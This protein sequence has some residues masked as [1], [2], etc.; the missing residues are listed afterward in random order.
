MHSQMMGHFDTHHILSEKQRGFRK[1]KS[2]ESQLL[3]AIQ[4]L[5]SGLP[6]GEQIDA[7]LLDVSKA[8]DK[9]PHERLAEKLHHYGIRSNTLRWSKSFLSHRY[10]QVLVEGSSFTSSSVTSNVPKGSVITIIM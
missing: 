3:I 7:V 6:E 4:D 9:V 1:K 8:F 10:Q 2:T 5:E